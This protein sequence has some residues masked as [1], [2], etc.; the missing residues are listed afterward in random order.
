[1]SGA[2]VATGEKPSP[3]L[4][5]KA[6]DEIVPEKECKK[7][8]GI[9][10]GPI[11]LECHICCL[12]MRPPFVQC[13]AGHLVC[14]DCLP[15][16]AK[17]GNKCPECRADLGTR[18]VSLVALRIAESMSAS[19]SHDGCEFAGAYLDVAEHERACPL[20]AAVCPLADPRL[21]SWMNGSGSIDGHYWTWKI[22]HSAQ[23]LRRRDIY[24]HIAE[25]HEV[26]R[27]PDDMVFTLGT[28]ER[29]H[30]LVRHDKEVYMIVGYH[31]S[32]CIFVAAVRLYT[33]KPD[34]R[35]ARVLEAQ[36]GDPSNGGRSVARTVP[37]AEMGDGADWLRNGDERSLFAR[38]P[39]EDIAAHA[40]DGKVVLDVSICD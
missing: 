29:A 30:R 3:A 16:I 4:K 37:V 7:A 31:C 34:K 17:I 20:S 12:H 23:K 14:S 28:N 5:R 15:A 25:K 11:D 2:A 26:H 24:Q 10:T 40:K 39:A 32:A 21:V 27:Y 36:L 18:A 13:T 38:F 35:T 1:M 8:G 33:S 6:D 9:P 22:P 19:C